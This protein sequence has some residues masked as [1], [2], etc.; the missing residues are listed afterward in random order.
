[1]GR[2]DF[3]FDL[4]NTKRVSIAATAAELGDGFDDGQEVL[5]LGTDR[6]DPTPDPV[7]EPATWLM[8]LTGTVFLGL[9]YRE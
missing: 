9:L 8:L 5:E 6:L 4:A 7:P 1:L 2:T 3:F